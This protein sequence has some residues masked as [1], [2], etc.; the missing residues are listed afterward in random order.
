MNTK[1]I[2]KAAVY[3]GYMILLGV[4]D[5]AVPQVSGAV[6]IFGWL[7]SAAF[8]GV[9]PFRT[10]FWCRGIVEVSKIPLYYDTTVRLWG[11]LQTLKFLEVGDFQGFQ[12]IGFVV[13]FIIKYIGVAVIYWYL[14][15]AGFFKRIILT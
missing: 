6:L 7:I 13:S 3:L 5:I 10:W 15:N 12:Y 9:M 14:K 1:T 8:L 4:I 11:M 2:T